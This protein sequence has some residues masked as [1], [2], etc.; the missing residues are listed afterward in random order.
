MSRSTLI[1]WGGMG[2]I[3]AGLLLFVLDVVNEFVIWG[4]GPDC[5]PD[6]V[7]E[8]CAI[9]WHRP[10]SHFSAVHFK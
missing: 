3:V 6:N 8:R 10:Y 9:Y 2:L 7:R 1:R 5:F 4:F